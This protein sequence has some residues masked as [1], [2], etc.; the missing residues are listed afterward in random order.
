MHFNDVHHQF[1][2]RLRDKHPD[3][4]KSNLQLCLFIRLNI[5]TK[6]IADIMNITVRGVEK[7]RYRLR[8]K[9]GLSSTDSIT[10]YL[11]LYK[12]IPNPFLG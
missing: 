12:L 5:N 3:L 6:E 1:I 2:Q 11:L 4:T 7:S 9:L 10:D 8:K